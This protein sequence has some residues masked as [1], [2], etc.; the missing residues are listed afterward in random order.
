MYQE[1]CNAEKTMSVAN[2]LFA[3]FSP[4]LWKKRIKPKMKICKSPEM[5]IKLTGC[6][7]K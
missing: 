6:R 7:L 5:I 3:F 4:F 2:N 1:K